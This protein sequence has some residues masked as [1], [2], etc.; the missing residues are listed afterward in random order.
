MECGSLNM[1][2]T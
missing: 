2:E 1:V